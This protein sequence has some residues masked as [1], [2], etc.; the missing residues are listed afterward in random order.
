MNIEIYQNRGELEVGQVG[1]LI[2]LKSSL[3]GTVYFFQTDTPYTVPGH[4]PLENGWLGSEQRGSH[5]SERYSHG[6]HRITKLGCFERNGFWL[7]R[8]ITEPV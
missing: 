3:S 2:E 8:V 4:Q 7:Y 6:K 5:F 1:Y